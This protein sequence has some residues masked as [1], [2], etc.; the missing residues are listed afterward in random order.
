MAFDMA[1]GSKRGKDIRVLQAGRVFHTKRQNGYYEGAL[2]KKNGG[3]LV[4]S[5]KLR[6]F[7]LKGTCFAY[8]ENDRSDTPKGEIHFHTLTRVLKSRDKDSGPM[9]FMFCV[10]G[11]KDGN[12]R[13]LELSAS[14]SEE[15][16]FWLEAL[17]AAI[18]EG[19]AKFDYPEYWYR[20]FYPKADL[21]MW[22]AHKVALESGAS[23]RPQ[24]AER[25][26]TITHCCADQ[27]NE[28]FAFFIA[29]F[30]FPT[31]DKMDAQVLVHWIMVNI[32]N[33]AFA[34]TRARGITRVT[35]SGTEHS[36]SHEDVPHLLPDFLPQVWT[37][38]SINSQGTELLPFLPPAPPYQTG[39]HRYVCFLFKQDH[40]LSSD[41]MAAV[42]GPLLEHPTRRL[43]PNLQ[44]FFQLA[45]HVQVKGD[46]VAI[47]EFRSEWDPSVDAVHGL[48]SFIPQPHFQSPLQQQQYSTSTS[49]QVHKGYMAEV[50][51]FV[52]YAYAYA[53]A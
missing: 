42:A 19:Y 36:S 21:N 31:F 25:P 16:E 17:D 10:T 50:R 23:L 7:R 32:P 39:A 45:Y 6:H 9:P 27:D 5:W 52:L 2:T 3:T 15:R 51:P 4:T 29:D 47:D 43:L 48:L 40:V 13:N 34:Q 53:Y 38:H 11:Y 35:H 44:S 24:D 12:M 37:K 41:E 1:L 26:P 30:G 14:T 33:R 18:H 49:G 28:A 46:P 8:Y 20:P 22:I